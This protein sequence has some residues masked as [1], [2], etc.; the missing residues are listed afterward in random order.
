MGLVHKLRVVCASWD[1][2]QCFPSLVQDS[3]FYAMLALGF[4]PGLISF[5]RITTFYVPS[6]IR[7]KGK[8]FL[9]SFQLDGFAQGM[10][11]WSS[12]LERS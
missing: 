3:M 12:C 6:E 7:L 11:L 9:G 4:P 8:S 10:V 2:P 5:L 1:A